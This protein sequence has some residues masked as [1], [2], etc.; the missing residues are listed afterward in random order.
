[1]CKLHELSPFSSQKLLLPEK[2]LISN[3]SKACAKLQ[4]PYHRIQQYTHYTPIGSYRISQHFFHRL[5]QACKEMKGFAPLSK[6]DQV[7]LLK[8]NLMELLLVRS[9]LMFH[10][11]R[12]AWFFMNVSFE[13]YEGLTDS[14]YLLNYF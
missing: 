3:L 4:N 5:I 2:Q 8:H 6:R 13:M 7:A 10:A 11:D 1:I 9:V 14:G 12:D